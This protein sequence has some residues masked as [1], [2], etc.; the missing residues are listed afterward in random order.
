M[1]FSSQEEY[2]LRCLLRIAKDSNGKGLTIPEISQ[3]EGM[4]THNVAKLLRILRLGG[5]LASSRGQIG[6]YTLSRPAD[7]ILVT[8]VLKVLGGR[9]YDS[10]F[11]ETHKGIV[12]TCTHTIDCSIRSLWQ[13][14]QSTVDDVLKNMS[15]KDLI[16]SE[17][18]IVSTISNYNKE[19]ITL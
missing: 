14:I 13:T 8:D 12:D 5:L 10:E 15:L 11:C 1:K 3:T 18:T 9:L 4:T 7:E 17:E 19:P 16:T 6:G 2:G